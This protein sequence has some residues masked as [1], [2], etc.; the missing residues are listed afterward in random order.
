MRFHGVEE[1]E[2]NVGEERD[3]RTTREGP[4]YAHVD[5]IE[6]WPMRPWRVWGGRAENQ[7]NTYEARS[8][9]TCVGRSNKHTA[10]PTIGVVA[11]LAVM[12]RRRV[13]ADNKL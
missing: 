2:G 8:W 4:P 3:T 7:P 13:A 1:R 6:L 9:D 10:L 5:G 12:Y 11:V